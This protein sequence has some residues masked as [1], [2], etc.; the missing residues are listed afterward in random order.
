MILDS[1]IF[2]IHRRLV[3]QLSHYSQLIHEQ[4]RK[5]AKSREKVCAEFTRHTAV[6]ADENI[7]L[8]S[9]KFLDE[10]D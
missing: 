8:E 2:K 5:L 4:S 1:G 10:G 9:H 6:A 7:P 3:D